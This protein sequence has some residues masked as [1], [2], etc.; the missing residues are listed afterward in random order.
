MTPQHHNLRGAICVPTQDARDDSIISRL[1]ADDFAK[2][3]SP[4]KGVSMAA[5][6]IPNGRTRLPVPRAAA[7]E[8]IGDISIDRLGDVAVADIV[9]AHDRNVILH[10][11][12]FVKTD[13]AWR[14]VPPRAH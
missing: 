1:A 4:R 13:G 12:S 14:I 6:L 7:V 2:F 5:V 11:T 3:S 9:A 8:L 10:S